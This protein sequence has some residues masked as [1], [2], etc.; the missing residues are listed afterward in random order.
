MPMPIRS[1]E[2]KSSSASC[3]VM[4]ISGFV[5]QLASNQVYRIVGPNDAF[6]QHRGIDPGAPA[7]VARDF[8]EYHRRALR[9]FRIE[10]DDHATPILFHHLNRH[11]LADPQRPADELV[12]V[13][14]FVT[15]PAHVE[16]R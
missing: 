12:L 1:S 8:L 2:L 3:C 4:P 9:G 15:L 16:I 5:S 14:R 7:V 11:F 6:T 13:K 10:R